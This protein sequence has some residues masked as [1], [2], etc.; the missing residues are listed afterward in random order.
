MQ[1]FHNII[2]GC[3]L[4]SENKTVI[5]YVH[6]DLL[7]SELSSYDVRVEAIVSLLRAKLH[8]VIMPESTTL[9][10]VL[11]NRSFLRDI[12]VYP[13]KEALAKKGLV[14]SSCLLRV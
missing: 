13:R 7:F 1:S 9:I 5:D 10:P 3:D 14:V 8:T 12:L 4:L 6:G 11:G 2:F